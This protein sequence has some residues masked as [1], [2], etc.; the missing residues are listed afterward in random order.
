LVRECFLGLCAR[1]STLLVDPVIPRA[2]DGLRAVSIW[3]SEASM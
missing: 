2:L 3:P 1:K